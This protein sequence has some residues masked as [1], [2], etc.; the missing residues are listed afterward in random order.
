VH[1]QRVLR[2]VVLLVTLVSPALA[3][4]WISPTEKTVVSPNKKLQAKVTPADDGKSGATVTIGKQT[5]TLAS[6]WMPVD[7]VLFDDGTLLTLDQWHQLGHGDVA[8]LYSRDGKIRWNK[9]LVQL[10]GQKGVDGAQASVSSIWWRHMPIEYVVAKDGK[11]IAITMHDENQVKIELRDGASAI[12]AV[13]NLPDDPKR[14]YNRAKALRDSDPKAALAA[15]DRVV[16]KDP[17]HLEGV[18]LYVQ[19]LH[20]MKDHARAVAF[21]DRESPKWKTKD[22]YGIANI[23]VTWAESLRALKRPAD[24]EKVLRRGIAAT[25]EYINPALSLAELLVEEKRPKDA[26]VVLDDFVARLFKA[27]YLDTYALGNVAEFYKKQKALPKA[28]ALYLKGY[29]KDSV[30]NQFL[31]GELAELY[32]ELGRINDAIRI[33]EQLLKYFQ[34]LGPSFARDLKETQ[35]HL[36]RLHTKPKKQR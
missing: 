20:G 21:L 7:V 18:L 9:T 14:L 27:S 3:D 16:A 15:L 29:K 13:A 35:D 11:S 17:D 32:E 2:I 5:F 34:D 30:T 10:I 19:I 12:V 6:P 25:P 8:T 23:C 28:L 1:H 36:D 26:D 4:Q 31:Y 22:G 24:A 33:R